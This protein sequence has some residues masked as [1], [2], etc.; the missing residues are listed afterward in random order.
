MPGKGV[1]CLDVEKPFE[2]QSSA[3]DRVLAFNLF[4]HVRHFDRAP[5]EI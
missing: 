2:L 3:N 4:V 1:V 5:A